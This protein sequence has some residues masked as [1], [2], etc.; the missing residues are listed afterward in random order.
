MDE[1]KKILVE[2]KEYSV[3]LTRFDDEIEHTYGEEYH[4]F[5]IKIEGNGLDITARKYDDEEGLSI[6]LSVRE[7]DAG[8]I[9]VVKSIAEQL[10]NT[11]KLVLLT[12]EN[13]SPYKDV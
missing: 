12:G 8:S 2:G 13:L 7:A 3:S 4:G 5:F 1:E 11:R 9:E 10:C 6:Q